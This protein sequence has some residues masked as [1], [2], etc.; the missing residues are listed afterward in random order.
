MKF[1]EILPALRRGEVVRRECFQSNLV[2][3]MQIPAEISAQDILKMKSI[4][5]K[6]KILMVEHEAGVTYHDQFIMYDFSDQSCTYYPFDGE[7]I[8]ADDWELVNPISY[9]PYGDLR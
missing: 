3:F 2:V 4:P 9:D 8:N 7:D 5:T 6:M 1:E